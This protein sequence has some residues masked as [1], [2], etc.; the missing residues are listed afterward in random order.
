M[1][2]FMKNIAHLGNH[3]FLHLRQAMSAQCHMSRAQTWFQ[4]SLSFG[5]KSSGLMFFSR[6]RVIAILSLE[7]ANA[8]R[9]MRDELAKEVFCYLC[10]RNSII[11]VL[12][13]ACPRTGYALKSQYT[14]L[15]NVEILPSGGAM[16]SSKYNIISDY[17]PPC[18]GH[19]VCKSMKEAGL[20]FD[21]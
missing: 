2:L 15:A 17:V 10:N 16:T 6:C 12:L 21:G 20:Q 19:G 7:N 8:G 9:V 1:Q 5:T 18:S 11:F 14:N 3:G 4:N 13:V